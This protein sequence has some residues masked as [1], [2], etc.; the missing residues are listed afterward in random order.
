MNRI[1]DKGNG[2]VLGALWKREPLFRI[3]LS[4]SMKALGLIAVFLLYC[5]AANSTFGTACLIKLVT[6]VPCPACGMT[7]ACLSALSFDFSTAAYYHPLFAFGI[8]G[9]VLLCFAA[10]KPSILHGKQTVFASV[11]LIIA[12]IAVYIL[13]LTVFKD[14]FAPL[15]YEENSLFGLIKKLFGG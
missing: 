12:F 11:V 5:I 6:G 1:T 14:V 9:V 2:T 3:L 13:R 15:R 8:A 10:V 4:P 7:H